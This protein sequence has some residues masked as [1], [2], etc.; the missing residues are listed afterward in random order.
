MA[1]FKAR[2]DGAMRQLRGARRAPGVDRIYAPGELEFETAAR[3]D[4]EGIPLNQETLDDLAATAR[5][6]GRRPCPSDGGLTP[7]RGRAARARAPAGWT[8][9]RGS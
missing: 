1:R 3:Y 9:G 7:A 6:C 2:V 5:A 8:T 4:R